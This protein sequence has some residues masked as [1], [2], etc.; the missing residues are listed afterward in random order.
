MNYLA[1][2]YLSTSDPYELMGNLWGDLLRPK[3][4]P[5]LHPGMLIGIQRHRMIDRY[6]DQHAAV[7]TINDLIRPYQGKYTPVVTDVL[8]DHILSK[9]WS[10]FYDQRI[11]AFCER[12]YEVVRQYLYLIPEPLHPRIQ[13]MLSHRW[14]ESCKSEERMEETLKMLSRRASF[15]NRIEQALQPYL[16]HELIMDDLFLIFFQELQEHISLQSVS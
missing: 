10:T 2:A 15:E 3:D 11:E 4:F 7:N 13:R 1:H 6:T 8:M 14:L 5:N 16:E 9:Y 12:V